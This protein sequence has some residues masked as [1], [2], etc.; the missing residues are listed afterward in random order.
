[1]SAAEYPKPQNRLRTRRGLPV[2]KALGAKQV[3]FVP[4][5]EL[6]DVLWPI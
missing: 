5:H 2:M 1:M 3:I 6:Q 4:P